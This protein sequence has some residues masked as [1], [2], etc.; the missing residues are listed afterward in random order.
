MQDLEIQK[1][2]RRKDEERIGGD[3]EDDDDEVRERESAC[4]CEIEL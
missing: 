3:Y 4:A 2:I 1:Q